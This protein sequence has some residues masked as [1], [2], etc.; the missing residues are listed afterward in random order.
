MLL[1]R[2]L[3][4]MGVIRPM[5]LV[6]MVGTQKAL[7]IGIRNNKIQRRFTG[8]SRKLMEDHRNEA[9]FDRFSPRQD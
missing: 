2:N 1:Q 8:L 6:I 5:K 4:Y 7:G 3:V 9:E